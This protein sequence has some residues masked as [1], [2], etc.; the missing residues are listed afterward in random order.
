MWGYIRAWVR[1]ILLISQMTSVPPARHS[2]HRRRE[3]AEARLIVSHQLGD[4][5]LNE[6]VER[7]AGRRQHR[8]S[9]LALRHTW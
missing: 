6:P 2:P 8:V 5:L 3:G 4:R 1:V 7:L 9:N